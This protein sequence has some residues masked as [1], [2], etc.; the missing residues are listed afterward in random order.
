MFRPGVGHASLHL[1]QVFHFAVQ[2]YSERRVH[3]QSGPPA[4]AIEGTVYQR[5]LPVQREESPLN[6]Y[7][8]N[9]HRLDA[10]VVDAIP[11]LWMRAVR[12]ELENLNTILPHLH[13]FITDT[14]N[15]RSATLEL[16][17]EGQV[18][19]VAAIIHYGGGARSDPRSILIQKRDEDG[20]SK[21][22]H[23]SPLYDPLCY[24]ILFP[25]GTLGWPVG[26]WTLRQ[27]VRFR[28]LT[29][30]RFQHLTSVSNLYMVDQMCRIEDERLRFAA[31][32]LTAGH[33][34]AFGH[35]VTEMI[36][37]DREDDAA[38]FNAAL[39]SSFVGSRAHRAEH[40]LDALALAKRY[41][42]PTGML[43]LTTNPEW[44]E[45]REML[46]PGQTATTMPQITI[47]VFRAR[48][49]KCL[50]LFKAY[51][52]RTTYIVKVIEFQSAV[53]LMHTLFLL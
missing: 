11:P 9:P 20:P 6:L 44:P 39:P 18:P 26:D 35:E 32:S 33:R 51:F 43:T 41:G 5:M 24:P 34:H 36:A 10:A 53:F 7:L 45:I 14:L 47:R 25:Q 50:A 21:L 49:A 16:G 38:S 48:L 12:T 3:F 30:P 46:S 15:V 29:E 1:N 28:L 37:D 22:P 13:D 23:N 27:Y 2:G 40:V 52:G 8:H 42:R 19:D 4:F 17:T 31:R